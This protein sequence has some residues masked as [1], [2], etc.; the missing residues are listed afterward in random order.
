[1]AIAE[2]EQ[3][4]SRRFGSVDEEE[5]RQVQRQRKESAVKTFGRLTLRGKVDDL[6]Q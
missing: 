1:M 5:S 6:P 4:G 3:F 2:N